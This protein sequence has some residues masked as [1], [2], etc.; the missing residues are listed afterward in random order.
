MEVKEPTRNM[1]PKTLGGAFEYTITHFVYRV[2]EIMGEGLGVFAGSIFV[3]AMELVEPSLVDYLTPMIDEV[4]SLPDIP[5]VLRTFFQGLKDMK[6]E[7]GAGILMGAAS[8]AA[9]G[10]LLSFAEPLLT[11]VGYEAWKK[12]PNRLPNLES[13]LSMKLRG[14]ISPD[15]FDLIAAYTG[16]QKQYQ[17]GFV[18]LA[19]TRTGLEEMIALMWRG[20]MQES[21]VREELRMRGYAP[22]TIEDVLRVSQ[23]IPG[24]GDLISMAVREA[25][26]PELVAKYRYMDNF[27]P[28][29]AEWMEKQGFPRHWAEKYW[30]AHW[31]L[32]GIN[33]AFVMMHRGEI[34]EEELRDLLRTADIAPTWHDPLINIA[35]SPYTRVDVRR[36]HKLEVL[37]DEDLVTAY[38]DL[39]YN[40]EKATNMALFT[41]LYNSET[42]REGSKADILR[43]HKIGYWKRGP[44]KD[45]LLG[46]G[47]SETWA[48]YYLDIEEMHREMDLMEEQIKTIR[49]L[50]VNREI[51]RGQADARFGRLNLSSER[52]RILYESWDILRERKITRPT[53]GDLER[54]YR[55]DIIEDEEFATGLEKRG[56]TPEYVEKYVRDLTTRL[57]LEAQVIE[58]AAREEEE[59]VRARE[60]KT[61][62]DLVRAAMD[63]SI[64]KF[65]VSKAEDKLLILRAVDPDVVDRLK[66]HVKELDVLIAQENE[67]KAHE[68]VE[69]LGE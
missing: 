19:T 37:F 30:T 27:P 15:Q 17:D 47:V 67:R 48:D 31:R 36:M 65:K 12:L 41:I 21:E 22:S 20:E 57:L 46:I 28:E 29:F 24:P 58:T 5:P 63:V 45:L 1:F 35:Y 33:Q 69:W 32:P 10:G 44:A 4:L 66:E 56:Y 64:A 7:G 13:A 2:L 49:E 38:M 52:V 60:V 50:Y 39:G 26:H 3:H 18:E 9:S 23:R 55:L 6:H 16:F 34:D 43:G 62:Y 40:E 51:T 68:K 42:Q 11:R 54:W 25:F 8:Q 59:K 14:V 61:A 53:R